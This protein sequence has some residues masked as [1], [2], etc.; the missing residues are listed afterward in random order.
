MISLTKLTGEFW[1]LRATRKRRSHAIDNLRP[2]CRQALADIGISDA[3]PENQRHQHN[4]KCVLD[5]S[6]TIFFPAKSF[7]EIHFTP[8]HYAHDNL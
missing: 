2:A 1:F 6:L 8:P 4:D 3:Q 5:Q 7:Q